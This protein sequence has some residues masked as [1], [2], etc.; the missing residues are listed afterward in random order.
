MNLD[1]SL[2][3]LKGIPSSNPACSRI[4]PHKKETLDLQIRKSKGT[5][6]MCRKA[7][8][9]TLNKL[10]IFNN[11]DFTNQVRYSLSSL[12]EAV[13]AFWRTRIRFRRIKSL[14]CLD[15][16]L[17]WLFLFPYREIQ[18]LLGSLKQ[19]RDLSVVHFACIERRLKFSKAQMSAFC[20]AISKIRSSPGL[21]IKLSL[22]IFRESQAVGHQKLLRI[23]CQHRCFTEVDLRF[24]SDSPQFIQQFLSVLEKNSKTLTKLSFSL[25][26]HT[27]AML[28]GPNLPHFRGLLV[29]LTEIK[30]LKD[31]RI[32]FNEYFISVSELKSLVPDF[33][34]LAESVNLE[35]RVELVE[36]KIGTRA[37]LLFAKFTTWHL[38]RSVEKLGSCERFGTKVIGEKQGFDLSMI[39]CV[40]V[41]LVIILLNLNADYTMI[42]NIQASFE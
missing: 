29:S 36:D 21:Q 30:S 15:V 6:Q 1:D 14:K 41:I 40:V 33:K 7:C 25:G 11:A 27:Q 38:I 10:C 18:S 35:V 19:I 42:K 2:Q 5:R 24:S 17:E 12:E 32:G 13:Q 8:P 34:K 22:G 31:L 9:R 28:K 3:P 23:L 39:V 4:K 16:N 37:G 26:R 20:Q